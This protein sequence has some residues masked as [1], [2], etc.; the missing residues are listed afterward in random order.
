MGAASKQ[1][2]G[3]SAARPCLVDVSLAHRR[4]R[5]SS[6]SLLV[7]ACVY[8][9][10]AAAVLVGVVVERGWLGRRWSWNV[11]NGGGLVANCLAKPKA[12]QIEGNTTRRTSDTVQPRQTRAQCTD[13][14]RAVVCKVTVI[15]TVLGK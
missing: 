15:E 6:S 4:L 14:K 2:C 1:K 10:A 12:P 9:V 13:N 11:S 8:V 5:N 7:L 3:G